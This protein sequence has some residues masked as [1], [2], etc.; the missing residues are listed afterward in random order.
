M[1]WIPPSVAKAGPDQYAL[2]MG[3]L[4]E[5]FRKWTGIVELR[6][7]RETTSEN[8]GYKQHRHVF[9]HSSPHS[10]ASL[11]CAECLGKAA[12]DEPMKCCDELECGAVRTGCWQRSQLT[13]LEANLLHGDVRH[14]ILAN[15]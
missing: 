1:W 9:L 15:G 10:G 13:G 12:F 14:H 6:P 2:D 7:E 11:S 5:F 3:P 8:Y 4:A